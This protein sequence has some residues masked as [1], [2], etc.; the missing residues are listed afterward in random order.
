MLD[1]QQGARS[2]VER[3]PLLK[4]H[5]PSPHVVMNW[6]RPLWLSKIGFFWW[7]HW[8]TAAR[9]ESTRPSA[10]RIWYFFFFFL[11]FFLTLLRPSALSSHA[12]SRRDKKKKNKKHRGRSAVSVTTQAAGRPSSLNTPR[13]P[14]RIKDG[15]D[16][17]RGTEIT[18]PHCPTNER[19]FELLQNKVTMFRHSFFVFFGFFFLQKWQGEA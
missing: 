2:G 1:E 10:R 15:G 5:P 18:L 4:I 19:W 13:D 9:L 3:N 12:Y 8:S 17:V 14:F 16:A 11:F 6:S 7:G